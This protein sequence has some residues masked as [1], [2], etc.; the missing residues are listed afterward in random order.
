[1]NPPY[2]YKIGNVSPELLLWQARE[3]RISRALLLRRRIDIDPG[4]HAFQLGA[5]AHP[6]L[7][8]DHKVWSLIFEEKSGK[9]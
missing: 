2:L 3:Q 1:M 4:A 7:D 9:E 5:K 6:I 8:E